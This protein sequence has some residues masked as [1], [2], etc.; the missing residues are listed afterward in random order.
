M[1]AAPIEFFFD[2][3][4]PYGYLASGRIDALAAKH[5]RIVA[6]HPILLGAVFKVTGSGPLTQA[7]LKGGYSVMDMHRCARLW[8]VP[9]EMPAAFPFSTVAACRAFY[10]VEE[11][12]PAGAVRLAKAIYGAAF[13]AG[14]D[15]AGPET[16]VEIARVAGFDGT[17]LAASLQ[18]PRIKDKVKQATDR[19]I[20]REIF[21]SPYMIVDGEPFWGADRLDHVDRWLATGG[22]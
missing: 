11:T 19:A 4:S 6:W 13:G 14:G 20:A 10:A 9:F 1:M 15:I 18:D 5:G 2:F 12:D 16:V 7:P 17:A 21:G 8:G 22:W 3:S